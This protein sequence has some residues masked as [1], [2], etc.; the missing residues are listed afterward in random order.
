M[1]EGSFNSEQLELQ[2]WDKLPSVPAVT[3]L[4]LRQQNRRRWKPR[5]LAHMFARFPRLQEVHYE[6]W[7]ELDSLQRHTDR[8]EYCRIPA[9]FVTRSHV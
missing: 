7:M 2:W 6:P 1:E 3:S 9:Q 8:R 4:L 5:S